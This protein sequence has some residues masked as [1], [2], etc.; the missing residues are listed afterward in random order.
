VIYYAVMIYIKIRTSLLNHEI[1]KI[2]PKHAFSW[3]DFIASHQIKNKIRKNY[4]FTH[5]KPLF[6]KSNFSF[7]NFFKKKPTKGE[8]RILIF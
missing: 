5:I 6:N 2:D 1:L 8:P 7:L 4:K 3:D